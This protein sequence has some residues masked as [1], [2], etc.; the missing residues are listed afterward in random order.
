MSQVLARQL[1]A[2]CGSALSAAAGNV[3]YAGGRVAIVT[4][5]P[6]QLSEMRHWQ[7]RPLFVIKIWKSSEPPAALTDQHTRPDSLQFNAFIATARG[8]EN[9]H[10]QRRRSRRFAYMQ[11]YR[12]TEHDPHNVLYAMI[13]VQIST[14]LRPTT[15]SYFSCEHWPI[16][17]RR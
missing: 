3:G 12:S 2:D 16:S 5:A 8:D 11:A 13:Y 4:S 1:L 14:N 17:F 15:S 6:A 9:D 7:N 10:R